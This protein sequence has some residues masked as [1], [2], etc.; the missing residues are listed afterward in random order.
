MTYSLLCVEDDKAIANLVVFNLKQYYQ[1]IVHAIDQTTARSYLARQTFDLI[2][3]D[4][5]LPDGNGLEL[6]RMLRARHSPSAIIML[7]GCAS[8]DDCIRGLELGADDYIT[9]P[10]NIK[11]LCARVKAML[12]RQERLQIQN[13][14]LNEERLVKGDLEIDYTTRTVRRNDQLIDLTSKEFALLDHFARHPGQVFSRAQLLDAVWSCAYNVFEHTVN[15]HIN[16][17]RAKIESDPQNPKYIDTVWG[18]GYRF[19]APCA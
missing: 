5:N 7:T 10:F 8:D 14:V 12:R 2:L 3:L 18:V 6:C 17:L 19:V 9:K 13:E 1:H 16:R 11:E 4:L 15:S